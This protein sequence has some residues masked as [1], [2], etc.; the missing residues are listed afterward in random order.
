[1]PT[2]AQAMRLTETPC[3]QCNLLTRA[4]SARCLHCDASLRREPRA[5]P[6][7]REERKESWAQNGDDGAL[8]QF[9]APHSGPNSIV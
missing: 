6:S 4:D 5:R 3:P 7:P 8:F 2:K 9:A 1:M